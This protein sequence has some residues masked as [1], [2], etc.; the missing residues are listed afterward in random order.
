M[1]YKPYVPQYKQMGMEPIVMPNR[2]L[3]AGSTSVGNQPQSPVVLQIPNKTR[4]ARSIIPAN[5]PYAETVPQR[6]VPLMN[7]GN[8]I[9]TGWTT[10]GSFS[11][12]EANETIDPNR[13]M[14]DNN[15]FIQYP[16]AQGSPMY[17]M[18]LNNN[19]IG[20][21]S[22]TS[23]AS[24]KQEWQ[25]PPTQSLQYEYT[26]PTQ[27]PAFRPPIK[28]ESSQVNQV[29]P[30]VGD[31]MLL[32]NGN[33]IL[34]GSKQDVQLKAFELLTDENNPTSSDDLIFLKRVDFAVGVALAE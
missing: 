19:A 11:T 27:Q 28:V 20:V 2:K 12:T 17:Q 4:E 9:E 16:P 34:I 1:N 18:P 15:E 30:N 3:P 21:P 26:P 23:A 25:Y 32:L 31:Y 7:V 33:T 22:R 8:N 6:S 10:T 14:V 13:P 29:I 24:S 5:V